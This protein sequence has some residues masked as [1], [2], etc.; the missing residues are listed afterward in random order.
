MTPAVRS[1]Q[2][3]FVFG[4]AVVIVL[5]LIAGAV[6]CVLLI[7]WIVKGPPPPPPPWGTRIDSEQD[8]ENNGRGRG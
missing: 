8:A 4:G 1:L 3:S 5:L 2:E 6:F 7:R